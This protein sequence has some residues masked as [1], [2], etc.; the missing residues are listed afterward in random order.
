MRRF[1]L[2]NKVG[3]DLKDAVENPSFRKSII[4][5]LDNDGTILDEIPWTS[6]T[7]YMYDP[8]PDPHYQ[9]P[10]KI[11]MASGEMM[12]PPIIPDNSVTSG[13]N[14][15]VQ[16]IYRFCQK[17]PRRKEDIIRHLIHDKK[18][19]SDNTISIQIVESI[20]AEMYEGPDL[21]GLL[22]KRGDSFL[23]G[24]KIKTGRRIVTLISG[25][26]PFE[27]EI[28]NLAE[29]NG[30][31]SRDEIFDLLSISGKRLKWARYDTTINYYIEKLLKQGCIV[32]FGKDWY[33]YKKHPE[34][35]T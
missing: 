12:I 21:G 11:K 28:L 19:L 18:V 22:I 16:I 23:S 26:D 10:H 15:F 2:T 5:V 3:F 7:H 27:Y 31:I 17:Q 20:I 30:T 4:Q 8:D 1:M 25:Y 32:K 9:K 13:E 24:T 34:R 6:V 35:M 14:P 29:R 33:R